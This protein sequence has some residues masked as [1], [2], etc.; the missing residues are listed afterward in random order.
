MRLRR[1]PDLAFSPDHTGRLVCTSDRA[2]CVRYRD[3]DGL[4]RRTL[5]YLGVP[6]ALSEVEKELRDPAQPL[7]HTRSTIVRLLAD[8]LVVTFVNEGDTEIATGR[9]TTRIGQ[10][11]KPPTHDSRPHLQLS[12]FTAIRRLRR[13]L[14]AQNPVTGGVVELHQPALAGLLAQWATPAPVHH[15]CAPSDMSA[16]AVKE[17]AQMM[18]ALGILTHSSDT[19]LSEENTPPHQFHGFATAWA[20]SRS[21]DGLS[22][23]GPTQ[24]EF[25]HPNDE[26]LPGPDREDNKPTGPE[27]KAII[28]LPKPD[29]NRRALTD[30][31]LATLMES[32]KSRRSY[33]QTPMTLSNIAE[34]LY[35]VTGAR[36]EE[37]GQNPN[38]RP[39]PAAGGIHEIEYYLTVRRCEGLAPGIYH[40]RPHDHAL[41]VLNTDTEHIVALIDHSYRA[42]RKVAV[43]H[44][45]I[46]LTS[47]YPALATKYGDLAYSLTLKNAGVIMLA[48][49]LSAE[50]MKLACCPV[51][52]GD[53]A[54]FAEATGRQPVDEL[55]IGEIAVGPRAEE[56][57]LSP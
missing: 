1:D 45:L 57:E 18:L 15:I 51:G 55:P 30:P 21:R 40:Y 19:H 32:R 12:R 41:T 23:Y 2:G 24:P 11:V 46:T 31:S 38:K 43:P 25:S 13:H 33:G 14:V 27:T 49:Q 8:G 53:A 39:V 34:L 7:G 52:S 37:D 47:R 36:S 6:R 56:D 3:R 4:F 20:H 5:E 54:V 26:G 29:L 50:A 28:E 44:I 42:L 16:T 9:M 10:L 22:L 35:R 17:L 48:L